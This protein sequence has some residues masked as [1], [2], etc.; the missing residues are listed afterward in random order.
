MAAIKNL[1]KGKNNVAG[2]IKVVTNEPHRHIALYL[3]IGEY[4]KACMSYDLY[5]MACFILKCIIER[6]ENEKI[7]L[8]KEKNPNE[9]LF[10]VLHQ[11][12]R[13]IQHA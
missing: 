2:S 1:D 9:D 7:T 10:E 8:L 3:K 6:A 13:L 4:P 5:E 12:L 11:H